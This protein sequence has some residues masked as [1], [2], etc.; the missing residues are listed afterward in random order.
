MRRGKCWRGC[1]LRRRADTGDAGQPLGVCVGQGL[2][3]DLAAEIGVE[4]GGVVGGDVILDGGGDSYHLVDVEVDTGKDVLAVVVVVEGGGK[5][6]VV[7]GNSAVVAA[8]DVELG[9]DLA[10][11]IDREAGGVVALDVVAGKAHI[12]LGSDAEIAVVVAGKEMEVLA[13]NLVDGGVDAAVAGAGDSIGVVSLDVAIDAEVEVLD[14]TEVET[15]GVEEVV[16]EL[17]A[18]EALAVEHADVGTQPMADVVL[19]VKAEVGNIA[20]AIEVE[21]GAGHIA[22]TP[23]FLAK[24]GMG[25]GDDTGSG[26]EA[27]LLVLDEGVLDKDMLDA[28]GEGGLGSVED[29]GGGPVGVEHVFVAKV[30]T[31]HLETVLG[32]G[33]LGIGGAEMLEEGYD[34]LA[35]RTEGSRLMVALVVALVIRLALMAAR[36]L[37]LVVLVRALG[38][39]LLGVVGAVLVGM[40]VTGLVHFLLTGLI[41]LYGTLLGLLGHGCGAQESSGK[42]ES[43]K[44][45]VHNVLFI[46]NFLFYFVLQR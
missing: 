32:P 9:G 46:I 45:L 41:L 14:G 22:E 23:V 29:D 30:G 37:A 33:T 34:G 4:R 18:T 15:E 8:E 40:F 12:V 7:V 31:L 35:V 39:A 10:Y 27:F 13:G 24:P 11:G 2:E 1:W 36:L 26:G 28:V 44:K 5:Q 42:G 16:V 25:G 19:E 3:V 6:V 20:K 38:L 21:H 43:N 17:H